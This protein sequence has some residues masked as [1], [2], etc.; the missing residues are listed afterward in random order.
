MEYEITILKREPNPEFNPKDR[1]YE[2]ERN[3]Q[4]LT[5]KT[6]HTILTDKE[7]Q[8]VKKACLEVM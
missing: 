4:F 2:Q 6:L 5:Q 1:Y 8:A 7:F 3:Q